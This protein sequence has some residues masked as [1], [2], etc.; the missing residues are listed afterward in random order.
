MAQKAGGVVANELSE[1]YLKRAV[2]VLAG[3]P[4]VIFAPGFAEDLIYQ[5]HYYRRFDVVVAMELLEH[6]P[7][8]MKICAV[9]Q[10]AIRDTGMAL[11]S[12][13]KNY[14][15]PL[16][17]HVREFTEG[18]F[19]ELLMLYFKNITIVDAQDWYLAE[20]RL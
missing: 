17:E 2:E 15:D 18:S 8:P 12:V 4:Q 1:T 6:V 13:P 19:Y 11:F 3:N 10:H 14:T 9:A 5:P 7:D 16:G 20:A